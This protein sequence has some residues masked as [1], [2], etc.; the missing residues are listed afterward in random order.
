MSGRG[1]LSGTGDDSDG[2]ED[3][4]DDL[5]L[6]PDC[7]VRGGLGGKGG[8]ILGEVTRPLAARD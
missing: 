7:R 1:I 2:E 5:L 8:G 6:D 3:V 4:A